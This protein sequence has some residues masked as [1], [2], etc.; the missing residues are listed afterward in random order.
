M[1]Y[2]TLQ[3]ILGANFSTWIKPDAQM[4]EDGE[5][6]ICSFYHRAKIDL[7]KS[8]NPEIPFEE[9]EDQV[10]RLKEEIKKKLEKSLREKFSGSK[11]FVDI[12][13]HDYYPDN[14]EATKE[15][16][17]QLLIQA[18]ADVEIKVYFPIPFSQ[19]EG[20]IKEVLDKV[21]L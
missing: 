3:K 12:M 17:K 10:D 6:V 4:D 2:R 5:D 19:M 16:I 11:I 20:T 14:D 13:I 1:K 9:I 21:N 8:V 18:Q 7:T 15:E